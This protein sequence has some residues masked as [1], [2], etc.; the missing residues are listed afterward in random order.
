VDENERPLCPR[1]G[2]RDRVQQLA[3]AFAAQ[4]ERTRQMAA[5]AHP[6]P[7]SPPP[8]S[9]TDATGTGTTDEAYMAIGAA[10]DV[11]LE[12]FRS[13][14]EAAVVRPA[15]GW[16]ETKGQQRMVEKRTQ[17]LAG[18][19]ETLQRHPELYHCARDDVV[20]SSHGKRAI[21]SRE[22]GR[23]LMRNDENRLRKALGS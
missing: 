23:L 22:A 5:E 1:C 16:W 11:V 7:A 4:V 19:Q 14:I 12:V 10:V 9:P 18:L 21:P 15:A 13:A 17:A 2:A 20:F 6:P 3:A 8:A